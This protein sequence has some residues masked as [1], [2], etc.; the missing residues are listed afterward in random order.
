MTRRAWIIG[1][2][3]A[4]WVNLWPAYSSLIAHSSRAD[5]AQLSEAFLV[6]FFFLLGFNLLLGRAGKG[7][8]PSELLAISCMGMLAAM[9][10]GEW[11]SGYFLGIITAPTYFVTP[12]NRWSD[13]LFQHIPDWSIVADRRATVG[14]YESLP[15]GASIPWRAWVPPLVWWGGFLGA[16]LLA[17]FSLSAILRK[18]W[19]EHERLSFPIATALLEL[20]GVSGSE[21]TFSTL[22]RNRL[23]RIGCWIVL[24]AIAWNIAG[25]FITEFPRLP[26]LSRRSISIGRGFP[27]LWFKVHPLTIA[28]G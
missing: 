17:G 10:Q 28:F 21:R 11:L 26:V 4:A 5:Y 8:S 19:M 16:V 24:G 13:V 27:S 9:M 1:L 15:G 20:T 6:P 14:F 25:W 12:E 23:F 7:L 2:V 18:Q 3:M 22:I